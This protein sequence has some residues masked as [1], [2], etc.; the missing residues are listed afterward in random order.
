MA[1]SEAGSRTRGPEQA[2]C[3][4][5]WQ[6]LPHAG[7]RVL[8]AAR[9]SAAERFPPPCGRYR[10]WVEWS[11]CIDITIAMAAPKTVD[12]TRYTGK[13]AGTTAMFHVVA[14]MVTGSL[15]SRTSSRETVLGRAHRSRVPAEPG[16]AGVC[17]SQQ[18]EASQPALSPSTGLRGEG[19]KGR[20]LAFGATSGGAVHCHI[21]VVRPPTPALRPLLPCAQTWATCLMSAPGEGAGNHASGLCRPSCWGPAVEVLRGRPG[22]RLCHEEGRWPG[23]SAAPCVRGLVRRQPWWAGH[24]GRSLAA[25]RRREHQH[26]K[27]AATPQPD[28]NPS[29]D[30]CHA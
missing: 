4:L 8:H 24:A 16:A 26:G 11:M 12:I 5:Q 1:R 22:A 17:C 27:P 3:L 20:S 25:C 10:T 6:P 14:H 15:S 7:R 29:I 13:Q 21:H 28:G 18:P 2:A 19:G 9:V 30:A 23:H